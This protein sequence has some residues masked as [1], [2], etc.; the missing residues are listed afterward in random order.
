VDGNA[1]TDPAL[2]KPTLDYLFDMFGEDHVI[3][4]SDW[5][6]SFAADNLPAIVKIVKDYFGTKSRA[7]AEK[8]FWKNSI[9]AY[10]WTKRDPR[11]PQA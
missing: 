2:Y 11:Q 3:F 10:K 8:Y 6:N 1:S 5:P 9:A 4:G 7:A